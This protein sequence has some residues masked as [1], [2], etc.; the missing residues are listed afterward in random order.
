MNT[1]QV[2]LILKFVTLNSTVTKWESYLNCSNPTLSGESTWLSYRGGSKNMF[3]R[4][5][6]RNCNAM[7]M[8]PYKT[9]V[10]CIHMFTVHGVWGRMSSIVFGDA[11]FVDSAGA[12]ASTCLVPLQSTDL[13]LFAWIPPTSLSLTLSQWNGESPLSFGIFWG[14][15]FVG[16]SRRQSLPRWKVF[17]SPKCY[18][19]S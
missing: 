17:W 10:W 8:F 2:F 9:R 16:R 1:Q 12:G 4:Q 7:V 11:W 15:F 3:L 13:L 14:R 19:Q 5:V 18:T 6:I